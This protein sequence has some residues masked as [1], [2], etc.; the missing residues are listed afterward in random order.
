[1]TLDK[2]CLEYPRR[3]YGQDHDWYDWSML[4]DRPGVTWPD[5]KKLAVWI[6]ACVEFYPLNQRNI[7]FKVPNG[8][9][10]PYPDLRHFS[11]REY[12]NRVGIYRLLEVFGTYGIRATFALNTHL[13]EKNRY[14]CQR[15]TEQPGEILCHGWNMDHLHYGGQD[16]AEEREIVHR[17]VSR[18]RELTGQRIRG[19]L[20]PAKNQ[21]ENTMNLLSENGIDYCADWVNDDMPYLFKAIPK[22]LHVLPLSTEIED[23]FVISANLH[24]EDSWARQVIDAFDF[25]LDEAKRQEGRLF[26]LNLHPWLVGQPHRIGCVERILAHIT[27][28]DDIW[29][30]TGSQIL[31]HFVSQKDFAK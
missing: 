4:T 18:L 12:G 22:P 30:A 5:G 19:W 20:S 15:L 16:I 7:P 13:A 9:T 3:R 2:A 21:S 27:A 1:M 6:N 29:Q 31:D 8:M 26:A 25:L 14:L 10:M 17:S 23:R 24:S 11:L 28:S